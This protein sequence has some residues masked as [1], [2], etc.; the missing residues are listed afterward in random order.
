[1]ST[2]EVFVL[3][4]NSSLVGKLITLGDVTDIFTIFIDMIGPKWP[5][6]IH[7]LARFSLETIVIP[8][9]IGQ[10]I[11]SS[12][13][14]VIALFCVHSSRG[15]YRAPFFV[16]PTSPQRRKPAAPE[17][18]PCD[19]AMPSTIEASGRWTRSISKIRSPV[20]ETWTRR[21]RSHTGPPLGARAQGLLD[22]FRHFNIF[23][24]SDQH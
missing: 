16:P 19:M 6:A 14:L 10:S 21:T 17:S 11:Y 4:A 18:P 12:S 9:R 7:K 15:R 23:F 1:M 2:K 13:T 8:M 5:R 3:P 20:G 22:S 24:V